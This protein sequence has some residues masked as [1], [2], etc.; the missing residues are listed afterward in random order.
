MALG[1]WFI[2]FV[3]AALFAVG[4]LGRSLD[5]W[6]ALPLVSGL[7][8]PRLV[9]VLILG[10]SVIGFGWLIL[11]ASPSKRCPTCGKTSVGMVAAVPFG[12]RFYRCAACGQRMKRSGVGRYW[13]ASGHEDDHHFHRARPVSSWSDGPVEPTTEIPETRTVGL[14]L[15]DK[16]DHDASTDRPLEV[17]LLINES[18]GEAPSPTASRPAGHGVKSKVTERFLRTLDAIRWTRNSR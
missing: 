9:V 5:P 11:A 2:V 6:V 4:S 7:L 14:L 8:Y 17:D 10:L 18:T 13:D 12:D 16:R 1:R 15:R 3:L